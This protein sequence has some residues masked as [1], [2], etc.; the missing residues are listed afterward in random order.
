[1]PALMYKYCVNILHCLLIHDYYYR[2][3]V[4]Q[5]SEHN[6]SWNRAVVYPMCRSV[7]VLVY[8]CVRKVYVE[9]RLNTGSLPDAPIQFTPTSFHYE[10]PF[11]L[12]MN[13]SL[14]ISSRCLKGCRRRAETFELLF[15]T[16]RIQLPGYTNERST[17]YWTCSPPLTSKIGRSKKSLL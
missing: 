14:S 7:C 5:Y 9:T 11:I 4:W 12:S 3:A 2:F 1:M 16:F 15:S 17:S 13:T 6:C 8:L 10:A